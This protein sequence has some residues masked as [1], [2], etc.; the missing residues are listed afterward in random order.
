L[1]DQGDKS[2]QSIWTTQTTQKTQTTQTPQ[3]AKTTQTA[4]TPP[5][6]ET[7]QTAQ[8]PLASQSLQAGQAPQSTQATQPTVGVGVVLPGTPQA[9]IAAGQIAVRKPRCIEVYD[10]DRRHQECLR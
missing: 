8:A 3:T 6:I 2:T 9:V 5:P 10:G 7:T 4:K 1:P